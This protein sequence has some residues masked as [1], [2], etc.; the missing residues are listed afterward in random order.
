VDIYGAPR[1][2]ADC[3]DIGQPCA[4]GHCIAGMCVAPGTVGVG[5]FCDM[6]REVYPVWCVDGAAC[7]L[8]ANVPGLAGTCMPT[9]QPSLHD[10]SQCG[11]GHVCTLN[12]VCM[13]PCDPTDR[14]ACA[15]GYRCVQ[16]ECRVEYG[17]VLPDH[18]Y[19]FCPTQQLCDRTAQ[20][21][22]DLV[23]YD[24]THPRVP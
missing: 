22:V 11:A 20:A 19:V 13:P 24:Q 23:T 8:F 9:C 2:V 10:D 3:A 16:G 7:S 21:C 4:G 1:C 14:L 12:G 18:S 15:A 17:C 5:A 6:P